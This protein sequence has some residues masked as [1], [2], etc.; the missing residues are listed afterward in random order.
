MS[1]IQ[2]YSEGF[3]LVINVDG[4]RVSL[5]LS[6]A[7]QLQAALAQA[8]PLL[9][10][11][12]EVALAS[13]QVLLSA[14]NQ[15][16]AGWDNQFDPQRSLA[17]DILAT[18][19]IKGAFEV[20]EAVSGPE[21]AWN[22]FASLLA[23]QPDGWVTLRSEWPMPLLIGLSELAGI[24]PS[25]TVLA[26]L[27]NANA[28]DRGLLLACESI[29]PSEL[30]DTVSER[31]L[32]VV[33]SVQE[34]PPG[35]FM[36]GAEGTDAWPFEGPIHE[37]TLSQTIHIM[38]YPV[39]QLLYWSVMDSNPA[40]HSGATRPVEQISW[41]DACRFCNAL[42]L[43]DGLEAV[44]LID[45]DASVHW[46]PNRS[47]YRLP[48]EAEWERAAQGSQ[49]GPFAGG[50][51]DGMAW[52]VDN[53]NDH[54]HA[55][56]QRNANGFGLYDVCG[57]VWEWCF[58]GYDADFYAHEAAGFDPVGSLHCSEHVCRGGSYLDKAKSLRVHLRG[59]FDLSTVWSALGCRLVIQ[60]PY[61]HWEQD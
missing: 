44:Y 24:A 10:K 3:E 41:L 57:N 11:E 16:L 43:Q 5:N 18:G 13:H 1:E 6:A 30:S 55:V 15:A 17:C 7:Q 22:G 25:E 46:D 8:V 39:T 19:Q 47:G 36:M 40:L 33:K 60:K 27:W 35:R 50:D 34:L 58:D 29:P 21:V 26:R 37:V 48:T 49:P 31:L 53:S 28:W 32:T 42:S 23:M 52:Y 9:Q 12:H 20:L 38:R 4:V 2:I 61:Q 51:P 54:T 56:G 59:R 45:D 14:L